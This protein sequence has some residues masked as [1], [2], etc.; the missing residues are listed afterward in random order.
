VPAGESARAFVAVSNSNLKFRCRVADVDMNATLRTY[1]QGGNVIDRMVERTNLIRFREPMRAE[2]SGR[3]I[4]RDVG[5][6]F[7]G[8]RSMP[9][10]CGGTRCVYHYF[11]S[12]TCT[13]S[14]DS[15]PSDE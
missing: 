13:N 14:A 7:A 3:G 8:S 15:V 5:P 1:C 4:A 2:P 10:E 6:P 9:T 12:F 11:V